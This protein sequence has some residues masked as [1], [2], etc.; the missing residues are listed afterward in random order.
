MRE[1]SLL[2]IREWI[3]HSLNQRHLKNKFLR[4]WTNCI[5]SKLIARLIEFMWETVFAVQMTSYEM[6]AIKKT[7][8]LFYQ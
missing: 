1:Y 8:H 2:D 4:R 7:L 3:G 6:M 5:G